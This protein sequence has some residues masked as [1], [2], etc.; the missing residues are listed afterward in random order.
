MT[1]ER[2][3]D[4]AATRRRDGNLW[5]GYVAPLVAAVLAA[6]AF[7]G[8]GRFDS[9]PL[10]LSL[11]LFGTAAAVGAFW[12]GRD[13]HVWLLGFAA[14]GFALT[15]LASLST[16]GPLAWLAAA[17]CVV[18]IVD[19]AHTADREGASLGRVPLLGALVAAA[20]I[21]GVHLVL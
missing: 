5:L 7:Y 10:R 3:T 15:G 19:A 20:V 14:A 18:A 13:W 21:A 4:P 2:S 17:L 8:P 9:T 16:I 1:T 6:W 12:P 11:E